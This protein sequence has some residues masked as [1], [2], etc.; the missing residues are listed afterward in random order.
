MMHPQSAP[1]GFGRVSWSDPLL[2]GPDT[3]TSE[4]DL[5]EP[6]DDLVETHDEVG[7]VGDEETVGAV[8]ACASGV[9]M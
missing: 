4:F 3:G 1:G 7:S 2:G 8:E 5:F 6:V 9:A